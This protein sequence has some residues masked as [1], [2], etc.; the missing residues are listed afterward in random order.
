MGALLSLSRQTLEFY[1]IEGSTQLNK[2]RPLLIPFIRRHG[3]KRITGKAKRWLLNLPSS[4]LHDP[5]TLILVAKNKGKIIGMLGV[6]DYGKKIMM[7]VV[8]RQARRQ[9]LGTKLV[10]FALH[11]LGK[12]YARV[13]YDNIPSLAMFFASGFIALTLERGVTGKPTFVFAGGR[14]SRL[15]LEKK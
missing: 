2:E 13:A 1:A 8:A 15:D 4:T 10:H 9:K 7:I 14:W 5:G 6:A 12:M 11:R 3:Q